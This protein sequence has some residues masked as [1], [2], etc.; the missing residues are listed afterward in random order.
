MMVELLTMS[1]DARP[2][3]LKVT[4]LGPKQGH[5]STPENIDT[6]VIILLCRIIYIYTLS[7]DFFFFWMK[8]I[9]TLAW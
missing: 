3:G 1:F 6:P 5:S 7:R 8:T 2:R 4:N 9:W